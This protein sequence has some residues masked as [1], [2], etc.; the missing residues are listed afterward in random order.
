M[1]VS[2]HGVFR[3]FGFTWVIFQDITLN[4]INL[5]GCPSQHA[6][7]SVTIRIQV[8]LICLASDF[9]KNASFNTGPRTF[10][11]LSRIGIVTNIPWADPHEISAQWSSLLGALSNLVKVASC[12]AEVR[13]A[14]PPDNCLL[15]HSY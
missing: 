13:D 11:D 3:H 15:N 5:N 2:L 9:T 12:I 4:L 14:V 6:G 8:D 1:K 7:A 10:E